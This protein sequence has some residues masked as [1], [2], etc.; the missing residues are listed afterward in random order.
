M[1]LDFLIFNDI[2]TFEHCKKLNRFPNIQSGN[3]YFK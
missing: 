2:I 3:I 1:S